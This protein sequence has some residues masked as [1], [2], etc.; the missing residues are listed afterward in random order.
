MELAIERKQLG[1]KLE[2]LLKIT[3]DCT[4]LHVYNKAT[5]G[6]AS[7]YCAYADSGQSLEKKLRS[8]EF[9]CRLLAL[10]VFRISHETGPATLN[11]GSIVQG[12][13]RILFSVDIKD[14]PAKEEKDA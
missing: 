11:A 5:Y 7:L 4:E 13:T 3:V 1:T 2:D 8:H 14:F 6:G 9:G 12:R 10:P